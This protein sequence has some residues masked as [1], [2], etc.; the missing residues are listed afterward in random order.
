MGDVRFLGTFVG[1]TRLWRIVSC[2]SDLRIIP[3]ASPGHT[4]DDVARR[5]GRCPRH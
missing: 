4:L 3:P 5:F 2:S 1:A